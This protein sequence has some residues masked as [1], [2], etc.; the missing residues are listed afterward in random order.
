MAFGEI[1]LFIVVFY[2]FYQLSENTRAFI[3][4]YEN[5]GW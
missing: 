5:V 2:S 3:G 4:F 1:V